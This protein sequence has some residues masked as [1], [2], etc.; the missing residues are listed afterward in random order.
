MR[1]TRSVLAVL[2]NGTPLPEAESDKFTWGIAS[3]TLILTRKIDPSTT[4]D[5]KVVQ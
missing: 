4:W 2:K 5:F 3:D 1:P